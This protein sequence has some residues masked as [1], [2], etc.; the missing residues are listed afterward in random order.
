MYTGRDLR[1]VFTSNKLFSTAVILIFLFFILQ[2]LATIVLGLRLSPVT[3]FG[4]AGDFRGFFENVQS[5]SQGRPLKLDSFFHKPP[6]VALFIAPLV[7][8]GFEAAATLIQ[9]LILLTVFV[10]TYFTVRNLAEPTYRAYQLALVILV[11][12]PMSF[13]VDRGNL[14]G[15]SLSIV[16]AA[17]ALM[18]IGAERAALLLFAIAFNIKSNAIIFAPALFVDD[19]WRVVI[20]RTLV[21]AAF[22]FILAALTPEWS[23]QWIDVARG[24][25]NWPAFDRENGSIFRVFLF[26]PNGNTYSWI[27]LVS[28]VLLVCAG[29]FFRGSR[30]PKSTLFLVLLPF[31]SAY[32]PMNYAYSL[33]FLPLCLL[34]Y[35]PLGSSLGKDFP[36]RLLGALGVCLSCFPSGFLCQYFEPANWPFFVTSLGVLLMMMAN[37]ILIWALPLSCPSYQH[38]SIDSLRIEKIA[39][40]CILI[41]TIVSVLSLTKYSKLIDFHPPWP[42]VSWDDPEG[43]PYPGQNFRIVGAEQERGWLR[44]GQSY[45]GYHLSVNGK[46][47]NSGLGTHAHSIIRLQLPSDARIFKGKIGI[48]DAR[49]GVSGPVVFSILSGSSTLFRSVEMAA[50]SPVQDF[51]VSVAGLQSIIL[52]V[53]CIG[54]SNLHAHVDWLD[55]E[56]LGYE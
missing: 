16:F 4:R 35:F 8:L 12:Y 23:F 28:T 25:S 32:P 3:P 36:L 20:R 11:S 50:G 48:D 9:F 54:N 40:I 34:L 2:H 33:V 14:D 45:S 13:L 26:A 39:T 10:V 6:L 55:L 38:S 37:S 7:P 18:S 49:V 47:Y 30:I 19:S 15:F 43:I 41:L 53:V 46:L 22:L 24:R 5:V 17:L 51:E 42:P 44:I 31:A 29:T 52:E 21:C 1:K 27:F 56:L